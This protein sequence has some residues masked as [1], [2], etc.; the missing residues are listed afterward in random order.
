MGDKI[1]NQ[2]MFYSY[3]LSFSNTSRSVFL[4]EICC[5]N[6]RTIVLLVK[7]LI[8]AGF[9]IK[10]PFTKVL[11]SHSTCPIKINAPKGMSI[12]ELALRRTTS[13]S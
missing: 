5:M 13:D 8:T 3:N 6:F 12:V 7:L 1:S 10:L 2:F 9:A 11:L 4:E